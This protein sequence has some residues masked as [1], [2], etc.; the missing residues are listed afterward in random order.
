MKNKNMVLLWGWS[1]T[2]KNYQ[3]LIDTAPDDV[4]I[5]Q[6]SY[7]TLLPHGDLSQLSTSLNKYLDDNNLVKASLIGHSFGGTLAILFA[8]Q[9]PDRIETLHLLDACGVYEGE[10]VFTA[11]RRVI[12]DSLTRTK[13]RHE[14]AKNLWPNLQHPLLHLKLGILAHY[15]DIQKEA[16]QLKVKTQIFWGEK[17][18]VNP[19]R[20]GQRLHS[21]ITQSRL[22]IFPNVGH[23][24]VLRSP[25]LF[26]ESIE[27]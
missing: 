15:A 18:I 1:N 6:I 14:T 5:Y 24:W 9:N 7:P 19:L 2:E 21:L 20:Q 26:W 25:E 16:A 4:C 23:D 27:F 22:T 3:K 17:D 12:T 10:S 8:Q 13:N 11:I